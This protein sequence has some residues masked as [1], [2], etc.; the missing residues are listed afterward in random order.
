MSVMYSEYLDMFKNSLGLKSDAEL[1]AMSQKYRDR[2]MYDVSLRGTTPQ[3][4]MNEY[5]AIN[6]ELNRRGLT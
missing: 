6:V 3:E 2:I 1:V 5:T 4:T